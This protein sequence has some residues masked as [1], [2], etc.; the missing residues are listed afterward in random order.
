MYPQTNVLIADDLPSLQTAKIT[1][2]TELDEFRA[3]LKKQ[4]AK[5]TPEGR[6]KLDVELENKKQKAKDAR[7]AYDKELEEVYRRAVQQAKDAGDNKKAAE[8]ERQYQQRSEKTLPTT[9]S[10]QPSKPKSADTSSSGKQK[11]KLH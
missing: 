5:A 9:S 1:T 4:K 3:G 10:G 11:D 2:R 8:L 6:K 7:E